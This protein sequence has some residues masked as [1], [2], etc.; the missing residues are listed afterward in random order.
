MFFSVAAGAKGEKGDQG[1]RGEKGDRGPIGPKGDSGFGSSSRSGPRGDKVLCFKMSDCIYTIQSIQCQNR[2]LQDIYSKLVFPLKVVICTRLKQRHS[3]PPIRHVT[4]ESVSQVSLVCHRWDICRHWPV[5]C[6]PAVV[7]L[8][9]KEEQS[10]WL[11]LVK[12]RLSNENKIKSACITLYINSKFIHRYKQ[13]S[14]LKQSLY[15]SLM[16]LKIHCTGVRAERSSG[17]N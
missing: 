10:N 16:F 12:L 13:L 5:A 8:A 3:K 7:E 11:A 2:N 6:F 15:R 14:F 9:D 17:K 1:E 4:F